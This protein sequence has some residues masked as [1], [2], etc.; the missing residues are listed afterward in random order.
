MSKTNGA[1]RKA[2]T[3][4]VK[5]TKQAVSGGQPDF[6][7]TVEA[8]DVAFKTPTKASSKRRKVGNGTPKAIPFTPTPSAVGLMTAKTPLPVTYST[9]DIDDAIPSTRPA[10][11]HVA[12]APLL[13]SPEDRKPVTAYPDPTFTAADQ[14]PSK[15]PTSTTSTLLEQATAH[16]LA[17][18]AA[19]FSGRLAPVIAAHHCKVFAPAGL[20]EVVDPFRSL[21]SGIMAQ[22][23]SGA[24]ATSIKN[25]FVGLFG[26]SPA[27]GY[28]GPPHFPP[29]VL[30]AARPVPE[31]KT[32]GLS[33]RKAEYIQGL[34]EKFVAG[35][36]S[37]EMLARASDEEVMSELV[38]I[39]GLGRWSVEMFCCFGLKRADVFSTGDLGVQRGMAA[40]VGKDVAKLKAKGGGKWK[41]MSEK[42]MLELSEKFT[43]Y[44][45]LFMWYMWRIEDV[46]VEAVQNA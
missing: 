43:P 18:D 32:A 25:K 29:P 22:Q 20:A 13:S 40:Y 34:A 8:D 17:V 24:A 19:H 41:Y 31:L 6:N 28:L 7:A 33:Q 30:V 39:R 26:A 35:E 36:L 44:R 12:N 5:P 9:G 11:P 15:P 3:T 16:L 46:N 23:V 1:K 42:D 38:K 14:S 37:A 10:E 27:H 21:A 2:A 45:S 4:T